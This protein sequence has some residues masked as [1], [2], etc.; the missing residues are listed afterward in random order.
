MDYWPKSV[1]TELNSLSLYQLLFKITDYKN[2]YSSRS[3]VNL[4]QSTQRTSSPC[5]EGDYTREQ[6][7]GR[8]P[9]N[10]RK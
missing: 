7:P 4:P 10:K 2:Q 8:L 5:K 1:Q 3:S 6:T 9:K